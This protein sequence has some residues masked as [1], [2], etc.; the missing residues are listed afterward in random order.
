MEFG[1]NPARKTDFQPGGTVSEHGVILLCSCCW[2]QLTLTSLG[3]QSIFGGPSLPI[4][5]SPPPGRGDVRT[6]EKPSKTNRKQD[7][8]DPR[9]GGSVRVVPSMGTRAPGELLR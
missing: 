6:A 1:R 3:F 7:Q 8:L 5:T 9:T 4:L 2:F